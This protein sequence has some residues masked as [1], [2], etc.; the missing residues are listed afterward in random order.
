[1][2]FAY[3]RSKFKSSFTSNTQ[4]S[5][6]KSKVQEQNDRSPIQVDRKKKP[7]GTLVHSS[8]NGGIPLPQKPISST[9]YFYQSRINYQDKKKSQP[10]TKPSSL[11]RPKSASRIPGI[12]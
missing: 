9:Q 1:M 3:E 11:S 12:R 6:S 8:S 5:S 2:T 7:Y 4:R 10:T